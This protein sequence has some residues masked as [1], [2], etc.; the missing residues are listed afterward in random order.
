MG[1]PGGWRTIPDMGGADRYRCCGS[2]TN[3]VPEAWLLPNRQGNDLEVCTWVSPD[4]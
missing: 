4:R 3:V 1:L 2:E